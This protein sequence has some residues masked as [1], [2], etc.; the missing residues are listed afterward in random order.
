MS[1]AI[2]TMNRFINLM[3]IKRIIK[4]NDPELLKYIHDS[5]IIYTPQDDTKSTYNTVNGYKIIVT[6][7][8][9]NQTANR[10]LLFNYHTSHDYVNKFHD[11]INDVNYTIVNKTPLFITNNKNK[12]IGI[13]PAIHPRG[14][15]YIN[16]LIKHSLT[17]LDDCYRIPIWAYHK[18]FRLDNTTYTNSIIDLKIEEC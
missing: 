16:Y 1:N 8:T 6:N 17:D 18:A 3:T 14:D 13:Y 10:G 12:P 5:N 11:G 4:I 7:K 2:L 9:T 15:P